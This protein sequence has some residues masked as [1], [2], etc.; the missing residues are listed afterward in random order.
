[1]HLSNLLLLSMFATAARYSEDA[2]SSPEG[3]IWEAG[4]TYMVQARELLSA[5]APPRL[6]SRARARRIRAAPRRVGDTFR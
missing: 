4:L 1:M 2:Q 5:C 6:L 3:T